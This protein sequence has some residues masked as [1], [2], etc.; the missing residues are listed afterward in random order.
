MNNYTIA[1][2]LKVNDDIQL[3]LIDISENVKHC[4]RRIVPESQIKEI[5]RYKNRHDSDK[6]ILARAFLY[7]Y[8]R[9]SYGIDDFE[10]CFNQ[11]KKPFLKVAPNIDFSF[12]YAKNYLLIGISKDKKVGVDIE[13]VNLGL[14]LNEL[15]PEIMCLAELRRF[16]SYLFRPSD[17]L[18]YFFNLFSA[19]E[20]I[21]KCFGTGLYFDVKN[22]SISANTEYSYMGVRCLYHELGL[23]ENKYVLSLCYEL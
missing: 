21:I 15:A 12:S 9:K 23:W 4:N 16:N 8:L 18:H 19:K 10:L 11:Y 13:H 1:K 7:E 6:R 20:S 5:S 3:Y 22:L 14:K 17:Q 2:Y